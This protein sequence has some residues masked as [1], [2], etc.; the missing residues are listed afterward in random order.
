MG[1]TEL[2]VGARRRLRL[3]SE[4]ACLCALAGVGSAV[5]IIDGFLGGSPDVFKDARLDPIG[6]IKKWG[7]PAERHHVTTE[8][9]Y[10]LEIDRIPHG[11]SETGSLRNPESCFN[12]IFDWVHV[13]PPDGY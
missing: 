5:N 12:S 1:L 13:C 8:D 7:Y 9:G 2:L 10:I 3:L 11:L 6:L 4:G